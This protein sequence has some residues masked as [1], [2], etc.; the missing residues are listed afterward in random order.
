[1]ELINEVKEFL[2]T[3]EAK[4][5]LENND[6]SSFFSLAEGDMTR[7]YMYR[8]NY[9]YL[10]FD[11]MNQIVDIS[12]TL[13]RG[14]ISKAG[15]LPTGFWKSLDTNIIDISAYTSVTKINTKA[16]YIPK[17]DFIV[18]PTNIVEISMSAFLPYDKVRKI[19][20]LG[21]KEEFELKLMNNVHWVFNNI[22][23]VI[24]T[25]GSIKFKL[26]GII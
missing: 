22:V 26:R 19:K 1:M 21:T 7:R 8:I 15:Y 23:E 13:D 14:C 3:S 24:C 12:R 5:K 18:I 6:W 2:N 4:D 10:L 9:E 16:F 20:Y 25:D 11:S 17:A